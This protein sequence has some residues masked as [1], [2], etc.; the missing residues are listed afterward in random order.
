MKTRTGFVSNSSSSSFIVLNNH[1]IFNI[2][3]VLTEDQK[4]LVKNFGFKETSSIGLEDIYAETY[5]NSQVNYYID[6]ICNQDEVIYFLLKNNLPFIASVHYG[7]ETYRYFKDSENIYVTENISKSLEYGKEETIKR[8][9]TESMQKVR[10]I[11]V[12]E[13]I[14]N[15]EKYHRNENK[16]RIC[17]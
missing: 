6:V 14:K 9:L 16:N 2:E 12:K 7:D 11:N 17:K 1:D 15:E 4:K 10:I 5:E 3:D 13:Y 8:M